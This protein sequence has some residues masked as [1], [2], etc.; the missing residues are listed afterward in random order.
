MKFKCPIF[1]DFNR[2]NFFSATSPAF[3]PPLSDRPRKDPPEFL[4]QDLNTYFTTILDVR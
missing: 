2:L 4:S 1:E 3:I